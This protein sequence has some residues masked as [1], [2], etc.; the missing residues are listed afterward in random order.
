MRVTR[1]MQQTRVSP[2]S[3]IVVTTRLGDS[4]IDVVSLRPPSSTRSQ[5]IVACIGA[6]LLALAALVFAA[7]VD[8]ATIDAARREAFLRSGEPSWAYRPLPSAGWH[9]PVLFVSLVGGLTMIGAALAL[10]QRTRAAAS[11]FTA[12][13]GSGRQ[14]VIATS[15]GASQRDTQTIGNARYIVEAVPAPPR[16]VTNWSVEHDLGPYLLGTVT[17]AGSTA[18]VLILLPP[19]ADSATVDET[20]AIETANHVSSAALE[21]PVRDLAPSDDGTSHRGTRTAAMQLPEG[22]R[23]IAQRV[24]TNGRPSVAQRAEAPHVGRLAALEKA[25]ISGILGSESLQHGSVFAALTATTDITSGFET[26]DFRGADD[27]APGDVTGN[28]GFGR[29]GWGP[30]GGGPFGS[31]QL[32]GSGGYGVTCGAAAREC[33]GDLPGIGFGFGQGKRISRDPQVPAVRLRPPTTSTDVDAAIIRR[34]MSRNRAK[35]QYCYETQVRTN[36]ALSGTVVADFLIGQTG[37][38]QA[39]RATGVSTTVAACVAGVVSAIAFPA[40]GQ[41]VQVRYPFDFSLAGT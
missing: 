12:I 26:A 19:V 31:I 10:R 21:D 25:S 27:G 23:G 34:Y 3:F 9:G 35:L 29:Q 36:H 24:A 20:I 15:E 40:M 33:G 32:S 4:L 30:G 5:R 13:D 39:A 7:A 2:S 14:V 38:V 1:S 17:A 8:A 11:S 37:R 41:S 22:T 6:S 18:L 28:F 16:L